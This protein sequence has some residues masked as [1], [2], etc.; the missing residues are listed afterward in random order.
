VVGVSAALGPATLVTS[1]LF[2]VGWV[3]TRT[4]FGYFGINAGSLG[5]GP[6]DYVLRS[7]DV[8][9]GALALLALAGG[10]LLVLDRL[11]SLALVALEGGGGARWARP[12]LGVV[13]GALVMGGL[14]MALS[15]LAIAVAPS[16]IGA[17]LI[18]AGVVLLLRFGL[19][20]PDSDPLLGPATAP[21]GLTVLVVIGLWASNYYAQWI[22]TNAA[23]GVDQDSSRFAVVTVFS[24]EP[25][26]FPGGLVSVQTI[27]P[28]EPDGSTKYRYTGARLFTYGNDR[29]FL[30]TNPP[31]DGYRSSVLVLRDTEDIR[32]EVAAPGSAESVG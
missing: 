4:F 21:F 13:G 24:D 2:Y 3:R 22:G 17:A 27:E 20:S 11:A 15:E 16:L 1:V 9:V 31:L 30:I 23:I 28:P 18:A 19:G 26:D 14:G 25:L 5:F 6:Q 10:A 12:T 32:V 29:W 8:G 7:A